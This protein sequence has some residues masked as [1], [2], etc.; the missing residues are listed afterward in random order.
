MSDLGVSR[1][2]WLPHVADG[3]EGN[4]DVGGLGTAEENGV[5]DVGGVHHVGCSDGLLR[6]AMA[7]GEL[8]LCAAGT[9]GSDVDAVLAELGVEGLGE[10][11][12]GELGGA[13]DGFAGGALQAGDGRDEEQDTGL[14]RDHVGD[15]VAREEEAG[16][17]VGVHELVILGGGGVDEIFVV[18]CAGVVDENIDAAKGGDGELDGVARGLLAGG[19]AGV[20]DAAGTEVLNFRAEGDE[21]LST[22]G[23]NDEM[24]TVSGKGKRGCVA[25][26]G[27][28][29]G[30]DGNLS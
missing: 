24:S 3:H 27:A 12:L 10:S 28:C 1:K 2:K 29:A 20:E 23:S 18:A 9:D 7:D 14:L 22:A 26:S 16:L 25:N 15:S 8:C 19:V 17:H 6:T 5:G 30:N 13:V 4:A 11:D 21:A